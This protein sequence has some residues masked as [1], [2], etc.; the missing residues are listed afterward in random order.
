MQ[1][2]RSDGEVVPQ[3]IVPYTLDCNDMRFALPQGY[4][5]AEPFFQYLKDSFDALYAEGDE[6][7]DAQHRHALPPAGPA[8]SWRC[9]A[10]W[11]ISRRA[12]ASGSAAGWTSPATGAPSIP[13]LH[14]LMSTPTQMAYTLEQLNAA[15]T[16][17]AVA[18]LDGLYEHSPWI[19]RQALASRPFRSLPQLRT[20]CGACWTRPTPRPAWR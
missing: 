9:S 5:H 6:T 16:D 13:S 17:E 3:L 10:S 19:A 18:M 1:V 4:S 8:A 14:P 2:R 20:R 11:T 15:T 7:Q 12:I